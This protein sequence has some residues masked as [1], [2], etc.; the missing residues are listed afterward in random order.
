MSN[1][2]LHHY[3]LGQGVTAFSTTRHGGVSEG[4]YGSFNIN[5]YCGDDSSHVQHNCELL[6]TEL[7]IEAGRIVMP[8]QTHGIDARAIA[9]EFFSLPISIQA[10]IL[11]GVDIVMTDMAGVCIGVS[12]ADCIPVLLY[13]AQHH[14]AAAVHAGWRGTLQRVCMRAVHAMQ[15]QYGVSPTQLKAVVGPGISLAHFEVGQEVYDQFAQAGFDLSDTAVMYDKWHL[16]LPR[17]N[18]SQLTDTGIAA[19]NIFNADICTYD[20]VADYFSARRL[21]ISSGRIYTGILLR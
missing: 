7:G 14:V 13:D 10:Q 6:A 18:I 5:A 11:D 20:H 16:D 2:Q 9:P 17:I 12:T 15:V 1:L 8:H 21:G 19:H 3:D 4:N